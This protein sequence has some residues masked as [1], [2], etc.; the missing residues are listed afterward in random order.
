MFPLC[1]K[2]YWSQNKSINLPISK[3]KAVNALLITLASQGFKV[4]EIDINSS[5]IKAVS[6]LKFSCFNSTEIIA[7]FSVNDQKATRLDIALTT[8]STVIG[9]G[10][11]L[12]NLEKGLA[13]ITTIPHSR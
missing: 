6:I 10:P 11:L 8:N 3:E 2:Q 1:G 5:R 12:S 13:L 7:T 4:E 9:M